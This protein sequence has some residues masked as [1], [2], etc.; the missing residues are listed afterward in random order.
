MMFSYIHVHE[1]DHKEI[2]RRYH[3]AS[4]NKIEFHTKLMKR[5]E[6]I[7]QWW[8]H[9]LLM[10]CLA[11]SL[12]L[13]IGLKSQV[14]MPWR[15]LL[16]A[17]ALAFTF[18]LP[19]SIITATTNQFLGTMIAGTINIGVA[20]WLLGS[21]NNI[22][23]VDL[24]P[25]NS[26]WTCPNDRVF[27]DAS[28]IWGLVEPKRIFGV[29]G[30]YG[31]LTWFFL[32][33]ILG[34]TAYMPPATPLNYNVWIFVGTIFNF[35]VFRYRKQWWQRYNHV[36]SVG[37]DAGVAF[38]VVLIYYTLTMENKS[39]TWW[40]REESTVIWLLAP[41]PKLTINIHEDSLQLQIYLT[42]QVQ[43]FYPDNS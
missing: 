14:Q 2:Y 5:Y 42:H 10:A 39:I 6:D 1:L 40:V 21:I 17:S 36:L 18:T 22:C 43:N 33:V 31:A 27:F 8:F 15:G 35:F 30:N 9:V 16:L 38:M 28:V 13:C 24:L 23:N 4:K 37:L 12:A 3:A 32:A 7:P 11:V 25:P 20:W 29:D 26:P 34:A 19:I 41:L